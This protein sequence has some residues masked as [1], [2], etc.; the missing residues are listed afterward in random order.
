MINVHVNNLH[1]DFLFKSLSIEKISEKILTDSNYNKIDLNFIFCNDLKLNSL[2]IEYFNEDVLTDVLTFPLR[3]DTILESEI[4][5][6]VDR[7]IDNA[8]KNNVTLENEI[9]RLIVH[10]ILHL[11][12]YNDDT[13]ERKEEMFL[14]QEDY[15]KQLSNIHIL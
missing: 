13:K 4:Y 15:I 6:S 1:E 10:S 2:K 14:K 8:K 12:G 11:L 5:I 9:I 3:N 7:A